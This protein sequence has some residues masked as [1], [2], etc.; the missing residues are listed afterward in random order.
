MAGIWVDHVS[1]TSGYRALTAILPVTADHVFCL[2]FMNT[3]SD[4]ACSW[5][6]SADRVVAIVTRKFASPIVCVMNGQSRC[7]VADYDSLTGLHCD[8]SKQINE[9]MCYTKQ[10]SVRT[11][12]QAVMSSAL[13]VTSLRRYTPGQLFISVTSVITIGITLKSTAPQSLHA[14]YS[15]SEI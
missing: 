9:R 7:C 10:R 3:Q 6:H 12:F 1:V 13:V 5:T 15:Q 14:C 11:W 4:D 8:F 2:S